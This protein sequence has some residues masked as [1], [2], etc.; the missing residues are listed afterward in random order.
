MIPSW[1]AEDARAYEEAA[2]GSPFPFDPRHLYPCVDDRDAPAAAID[3]HYF[4]MDLW[5][6]RKVFASGTH[7]HVD[8]GSRIDG[9]VSHLLSFGVEVT[10]IDVRPLSV[11]VDGLT[12]KRADATTMSGF[13]DNSIASLSSLHAAEHFGLSRYGD[14]IDPD[15]CFRAMRSFARVLAP[16]GRLLFAVPV[17]M[18]HVA[19]N[20]HRV[21]APATV[22]DT[23][24]SAGLRLLSFDA[25]DDLGDFITNASPDTLARARYACGLFE[26]VKP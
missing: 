24:T 19:F 8:V 4:R 23:F 25:I 14:P 22:I 12:F 18:Q 21:F 13:A 5:A 16:R 1:F 10:A 15:A 9:F 20:A 6:A 3:P 2:K 11:H 26:F 7:Y 17:G